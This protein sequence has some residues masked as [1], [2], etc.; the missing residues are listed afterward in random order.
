MARTV[1]TIKAA[2]ATTFMANESMAERYGFTVGNSF[3]ETFSKVSFESIVFYIQAMSIFVLESLWDTFKSEVETIIANDRAHRPHWYQ[4]Q[5]MLFMKDIAYNAETA[6]YDT[7]SMTDDAI[8]LARVVKYCTA[9]ESDDASILTIKVAGESNGIRIKLDSGTETQIT[10]YIKAFRDAG[11]KTSLVNIDPDKF[12]CSL[13]IY[14]DPI[15]TPDAVSTAVTAAI[16]SYIEN[17]P[18]N[19]EYS[20]SGLVDAVQAVDGVKVPEFKWAKSCASTET[21]M[22]GINGIK[23]PTAGYFT[24]DT[25]TLNMI[26]HG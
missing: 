8:T 6:A 17:L 20:N 21:V 11:V 22:Q 16:T 13:D 4:E 12:S 5:V 1:A 18:F 26:A 2:L 24:A 19:A 10:A 15:F 7:S 3:E 25:I 23:V 14:Y 9:E